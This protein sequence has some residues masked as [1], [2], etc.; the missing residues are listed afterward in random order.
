MHRVG[1]PASLNR[2]S[3]GWHVG[4]ADAPD[5][6]AGDNGRARALRRTR[7]GEELPAKYRTCC[8]ELLPFAPLAGARR[9]TN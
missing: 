1:G 7:A 6:V 8:G 3:V 2:L 9:R 5:L 4:H